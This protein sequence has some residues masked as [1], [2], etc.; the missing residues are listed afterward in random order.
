M[1][2]VLNTLTLGRQNEFIDCEKATVRIVVLP[3]MDIKASWNST[4]E[5]LEQAYRLLEFTC[6]LLQNKKY[7]EYR[8]MVTTQ[9]QWTI[10]KYLMVVLRPF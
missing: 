5:L 9:D 6:E 8:P 3:I 4:L 1:L 2:A 7:T 10:M